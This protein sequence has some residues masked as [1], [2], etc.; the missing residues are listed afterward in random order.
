MPAV[1]AGREADRL[2]AGPSEG[3]QRAAGQQQHRDADEHGKRTPQ[4]P[5]N[6]E[7]VHVTL[8]ERR[9]SDEARMSA[10]PTA[11]CSSMRVGGWCRGVTVKWK[12]VPSTTPAGTVTC[13]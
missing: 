4:A 7:Q 6:R 3:G 1:S 2:T 5:E 13:S 8:H 11:M 9:R 10:Q 12:R